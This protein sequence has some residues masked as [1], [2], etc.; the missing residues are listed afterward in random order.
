VSKSIHQ[1]RNLFS[2]VGLLL[3]LCLFMASTASANFDQVD[4]FPSVEVPQGMAVNIDG[5]GGADPGTVYAVTASVVYGTQLLRYNSKGELLGSTQILGS[6]LSVAV[7]QATGNV[8]VLIDTPTPGAPHVLVYSPDGTHLIASF[9]EAVTGGETIDETPEKLHIVYKIAVDNLGTVY[10]GDNQNNGVSRVMVFKPQ[11]PGDYEHYVY[12]GR[13]ND[14]APTHNG[15]KYPS[16]TGLNIDFAGN[17]YLATTE[18]INEFAPG[19]P[20]NPVCEFKLPS[21][22]LQGMTVNPENGD[23]FYTNGKPTDGKG[24][25][26]ACNSE[27]KFVEVGSILITPKAGS[28]QIV[29]LA[30]NPS[31]SWDAT[32]PPGILYALGSTEGGLGYVFAGAQEFS[33]TVESESVSRIGAT[34]A[35]LGASINPKGSP[36]RYAFQYLDA[37]AY[38]A[39]EPDERQSLTVS[40]T[41]GVFGLGFEGKQ[42]GGVATATL[43][44]GSKAATSLRT[45]TGTATLK[46]AKGTATLNGITGKGTVISGSSTITSAKADEGSFEAGNG[47]SGEGIPAGTKI[48]SVTPEE[49]GTVEIAI[50]N[51]AT[52]SAAHTSLATGTATLTEVVAEKG[53]FEVGQQISGAGIPDKTTISA[54]GPGEL[55]LSNP[56]SAPAKGVKLKAGSPTLTAVVQGIGGFKVGQ[57]IEGQGIDS[58]TTIVAVEGDTL[59]LSKLPL[60]PGTG[61][62]IASPEVGSLAVGEQI[63]GPGIPAGTTIVSIEAGQATLSDAA[64]ENGTDVLLKAG[65]PFNASALKVSA[66]MEGLSTIGQGNVKVSGGPGDEAG[67]SPYEITFIGKFENVDVDQLSAD[68]SNLSGG[69]A[70]ATAQ[71]E[72]DG[73]GGF[74]GATEVPVGGAALGEG[75]SPISAAAS[76]SG[77]TPDTGYRF[78]AVATSHCSSD[79]AKVCEGVGFSEAFRTL[80]LE[81]PG[82]PDG[83]AYELVSPADKHGGEVFPAEPGI[84]SCAEEECKPGNGG[85]QFFP[86]QSSPDGEAVVYEG[87]PFSFTAGAVNENE[88]LSRRDGSAGWETT[89]LSPA[90]QGNGEAQGYEAFNVDL[91][92][93]LLYQTAAP[94]GPGAPSGF[95]NIYRQSVSDSSTLIP[96]LEAEPP[97]RLPGKLSLKYAGASADLSHVFFEANDALTGETP[98]AP[99]AVDGGEGKNN[100]YEW[101]EEGLRL[102]NVQP[103]N[104]ETFPG[105]TI[106]AGSS[107]VTNAISA[108]GSRVF[109]G[110]ESGQVYVRE[111]GEKTREISD[112]VGKFLTASINGS[113]LLLNDGKLFDLE[114]E[115][116]TDLTGGKGGFQGISGQSDD[117]SSIYF[118]DT[119]VLDEAPNSQGDVAEAG[120]NNLYAWHEGVSRFIAVLASED[121]PQGGGRGVWA[122]YPG[123]RTAEAS[124][125]GR[126]LAFRSQG[127]LTGYDN[128]GPCSYQAATV[129]GEGKDIP[130]Y[131][132][133]GTCAEVFLYDSQSHTLICAS[134][135]PSGQRPIGPSRLRLTELAPRNLPQPRYLTDSGRLYFDSQDSLSPFDT[136]GVGTRTGYAIEDVYQYEPEGVGSCKRAEGCVNLISAGHEPVDSNLLTIDES[137]KN[138]FFTTRDKL[139]LKDKDELI[140]LYDAREGGGIPGETETGRGECQG[141]ACQVP[142]SPPNDPTPGSSTFQ[143]AGNV[144]EPKVAKK[145]AKKHKKK[146]T[147]KRHAHKRAAKRNRGGAK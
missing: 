69:P 72:H 126:W 76:L 19:E 57:P 98:F 106:G 116:T 38:A 139:V 74:A 12:T 140:D 40:A 95:A 80:P 37:A 61:V 114:D 85:L 84:G 29:A 132:K 73:G 131:Y 9:G 15:I 30:F 52:K 124:P 36:T 136:N 4:T 121:S 58:N 117:L 146:H 111:N 34:T 21:A 94:L 128:V 41:G 127:Q 23:V 10:V 107:V 63:E 27:G 113:K 118:V 112:H 90:L 24:H 7:D 125:N 70:T 47:I 115:T 16:Y 25:Q 56:A 142:V 129:D 119:A 46:A 51:P 53:S 82:L 18:G 28:N 55:V 123:W 122:A 92:E 88:F 97:N 67:S 26:L 20:L 6:P 79:K 137:G 35:T 103:G 5:V 13:G 14:I 109:W 134:C 141:E 91:T 31:I 89:I 133:S 71:T 39:N 147:K 99:E 104:T 143:G 102:V 22:G 68:A 1:I 66:A 130:A 50:S 43:T 59:T 81:T 86:M 49:A 135:N 96:A 120:K 45:A 78:R 42:L 87:F 101:S 145:H 65:I 83:R 93:G 75:Q 11:T 33:P 44:S 100:L 138:V 144:N 62:A 2:G 32:R 54:V 64:T 48:V 17:I 110:S 77:L 108:N 3:T 8:Y 60:E 105:A